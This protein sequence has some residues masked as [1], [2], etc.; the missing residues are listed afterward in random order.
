MMKIYEMIYRLGNDETK[1][2]IRSL[3]ILPDDRETNE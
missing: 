3:G 1:A 2:Q